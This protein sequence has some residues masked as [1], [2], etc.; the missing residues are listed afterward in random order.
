MSSAFVILIHSGNGPTHYD[1]MIRQDQALATWQLD[2][3]PAD[4]LPGQALTARRLQDHRLEYLDYEGPVSRQRG[5]VRRLD[6]GPCRLLDCH[7]TAWRVQLEGPVV[8]GL[9][10]LEPSALPDGHWALTRLE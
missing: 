2:L 7:P 1:L 8:R 6:R 5:E 9:F 4:L 3:S 10:Q